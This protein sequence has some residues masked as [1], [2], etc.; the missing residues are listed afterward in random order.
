MDKL[1][2]A[3][4]QEKKISQALELFLKKEYSNFDYSC[5]VQKGDVFVEDK[6]QEEIKNY[7]E[8]D[9]DIFANRK[10]EFFD[11]V[12]LIG[13]FN[14][15]EKADY[16]KD[17]TKPEEQV[18]VCGKIQ[19]IQE[20]VIK[21]KP[22]S[23]KPVKNGAD[24]N[25]ETELTDDVTE[26]VEQEQDETKYQRKMYK[27][28]LADFTG[29]IGCVFFSN[30]ANQAAVEKL[31]K[32]S[33][34]VVRGN[35]EDDKFSGGVSLRVKDIAYCLLPEKFEE[36]IEYRKEKHFYEENFVCSI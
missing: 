26:N 29:E 21:T 33:V 13:E 4:A 2:F 10:I 19:S 8:E 16:I 23:T 15:G 3:H 6:K 20:K 32:G 5:L 35:L 9:V 27:F 14:E 11:I 28:T 22:K 24:E 31:E 30:K 17:K 25:K 7:R 1:S 12:P 34:I 36:H 18:V